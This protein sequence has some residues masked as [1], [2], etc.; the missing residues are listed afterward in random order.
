[1]ADIVGTVTDSTGAVV[2]NAKVTVSN[3]ARAF[4]RELVSNTAGEYASHKIPIGDYTVTAE[5]S[6]G[7]RHHHLLQRRAD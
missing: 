5:A 4:T 2:P 3:A 7:E 6:G 1:L